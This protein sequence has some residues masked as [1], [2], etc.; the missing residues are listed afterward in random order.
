MA[1]VYASHIHQWAINM[2]YNVFI[3]FFFSSSSFNSFHCTRA[4]RALSLLRCDFFF[5]ILSLSFI[6]CS[7]CVSS[8]VVCSYSCRPFTF[9]Q[10]C[11]IIFTMDYFSFLY[12]HK[13]AYKTVALLL[14]GNLFP[15]FSILLSLLP[16]IHDFIFSLFI[17]IVVAIVYSSKTSFASWFYN[18]CHMCGHLGIIRTHTIFGGLYVL[19]P[20]NA[21][22]FD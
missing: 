22:L 6:Q 19:F 4:L 8:A 13:Y 21:A 7:R 14:F 5:S 20:Y 12:F 16:F 15:Y 11:L 3:P 2:E 18:V 1:S 17:V 10:T 9:C